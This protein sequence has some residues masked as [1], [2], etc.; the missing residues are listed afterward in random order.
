M[1]RNSQ[2]FMVLTLMVVLV[3][4]TGCQSAAIYQDNGTG[5]SA[6]T[7]DANQQQLEKIP[8]KGAGGYFKARGY[9]FCDMFGISFLFGFGVD[10]NARA[11][12]FFQLGG[13][14]YDARRLGFIGRFPGWWREARSEGGITL[15][16]GQR[17]TRSDIEG[18]IQKYFPNGFYKRPETM[19]LDSKDRTVDE[20]GGT[21]FLACI[22][23][24]AFFRPVEFA[25]FFMGWF[26][27]DFK[28]DD[29]DLILKGAS[30]TAPTK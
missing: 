17:L 6:Y 24:D 16:Y 30:S 4:G 20:I 18:P 26:T 29:F 19:N 2:S 13:G 11:T 14:L 25:D 5:G 23:A 3:A 10:V 28:A 27:V 8:L 7:P 9:D 15:A 22:G 12:Q 1:I 21:A